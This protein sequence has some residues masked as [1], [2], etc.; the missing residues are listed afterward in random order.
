MYQVTKEEGMLAFQNR[1]SCVLNV[2]QLMTD[3]K[4]ETTDIRGSKTTVDF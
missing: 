1:N 3:P 4:P 2:K